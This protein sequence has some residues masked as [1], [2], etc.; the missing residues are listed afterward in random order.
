MVKK[1]T[2]K[3]LFQNN[4]PFLGKS[5]KSAKIARISEIAFSRCIFA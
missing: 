2:V 4:W 1:C 3:K 5:V